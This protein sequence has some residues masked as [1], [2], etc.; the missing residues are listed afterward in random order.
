MRLLLL[1]C[2]LSLSALSA[3][4][5]ATAAELSLTPVS[6]HLD[7]ARD[8]AAIHV[9]NQG[10]EPATMQAEGVRWQRTNGADSDEPSDDLLVSPPIFTIAPGQT[11]IVRIGVRRTHALDREA[12][13]RL[14]LREV[15][16]AAGAD[17]APGNVRVLVAMKL[18]VYV[19]PD[20]VR[21]NEQ[22]RALADDEG[23]L[24]AQVS[25]AGNV[26]YR[27][28][29]VSVRGSQPPQL[30]VNRGPE[31]VVFPGEARTFRFKGQRFSTG[32]PVLLEVTTDRGVQHVP[33]GP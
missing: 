21:R 23:N 20:V 22:W 15:P 14:L 16:P 30:I 6:V 25:N 29:S 10:R 26:H 9:T 2:L 13:Y 27:V 3:P 5:T 24:V 12:T 28:A 31:A 11:Q 32:M 4:E 1:T 8:R 19:A 18:P 17:A 7:R 33:L